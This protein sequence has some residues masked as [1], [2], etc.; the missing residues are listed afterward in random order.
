M[1]D[2]TIADGV[3]SRGP[4]RIR[5][6][7]HAWQ[8]DRLLSAPSTPHIAVVARCRSL[9]GAK[10]ATANDV[11]RRVRTATAAIHLA[12]AT[13][14]G[15]VFAILA[16]SPSVIGYLV[17]VFALAA[18]LRSLVSAIGVKACDM[19]G[20]EPAPNDGAPGLVQLVG[21]ALVRRVPVPQTVAMTTSG[22]VRVL[23]PAR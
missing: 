7:D 8:V 12:A 2:W 21:A 1:D 15:I 19:F 5:P 4:Y 17:A 6:V 13:S 16:T 11:A 23:P 3:H 20:F 22:A 18:A 9:D 10:R 14:C